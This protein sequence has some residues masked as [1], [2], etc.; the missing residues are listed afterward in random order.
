MDAEGVP[1]ITHSMQRYE[2]FFLNEANAE[3]VTC[4]CYVIHNTNE[5]N[6]IYKDDH[7]VS[8]NLTITHV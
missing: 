4:K 7:V 8:S 3:I 5:I 2:V 6:K 1:E